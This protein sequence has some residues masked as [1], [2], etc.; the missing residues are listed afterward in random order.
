ML[1]LQGFAGLRAAPGA[2]ERLCA[3]AG[4]QS[5]EDC[6]RFLQEAPPRVAA[7]VQDRLWQLFGRYREALE[8][9][10]ALAP[11]ALAGLGPA[12]AAVLGTA[13]GQAM[14]R[15][16]RVFRGARGARGGRRGSRGGGACGACRGGRRGERAARGG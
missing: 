13:L 1:P 10:S 14:A 6:A 12:F 5:A 2:L 8:N 7:G 15:G 3:D 16:A 4:A 11:G 9:P